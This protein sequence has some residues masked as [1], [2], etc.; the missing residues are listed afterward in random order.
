VSVSESIALLYGRGQL[1]LR[2]P[3][4][5]QVTLIE[6]GKLQKIADPAAGVRQALSEPINSPSLAERPWTQKRLHTRLRHYPTGAQPS[7]PAA[8]D[9]NDGRLRH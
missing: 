2:M 8:D 4:H 3:E 9:R 1:T 5:A 7:L 6:K